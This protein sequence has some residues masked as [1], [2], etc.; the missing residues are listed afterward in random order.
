M[1]NTFGFIL[2]RGLVFLFFVML[3]LATSARAGEHGGGEGGGSS[4]GYEKLEPFTV[5]LVGLRQMIQISVTLKPAKADVSD[6]IKLYMPAIRHEIIL[7][8]SGKTVEQM[9][10]SEGK[11][12]LILETRYAANKALGLTS[13]DGVADVLFESII[14]Q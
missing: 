8:L 14:I 5:N 6:K 2:R 9:Q 3:G 4:G 1:Q 10:S 11:Q 12:R 7:L 13:K